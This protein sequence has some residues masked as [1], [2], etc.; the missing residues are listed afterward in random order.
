MSLFA[1]ACAWVRR[2]TKAQT[3]GWAIPWSCSHEGSANSPRSGSAK[4]SPVSVP[5]SAKIRPQPVSECSSPSPVF[6]SAQSIPSQMLPVS[7]QIMLMLVLVQVILRPVLVQIILKSVSGQIILRPVLVQ[8]GPI[9]EQG[10]C[11][12][13]G[14][15]YPACV[16]VGDD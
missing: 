7:V 16:S 15:R 10:R 3:H 9:P 13:V 1:C 5:V 8:R 11:R 2:V 12:R 6:A 4:K 14:Q